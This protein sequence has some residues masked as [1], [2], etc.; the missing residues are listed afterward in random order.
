MILNIAS[1]TRVVGVGLA[2][3]RLGHFRKRLDRAKNLA[4]VGGPGVTIS[5]EEV[6]HKW[7]GGSPHHAKLCSR[8]MA[9]RTLTRFEIA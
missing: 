2:S 7:N 9:C 3:N 1:E 5:G 4:I 6:G 8:A